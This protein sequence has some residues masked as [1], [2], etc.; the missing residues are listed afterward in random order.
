MEGREDD[1]RERGA[2]PP[3]Y[4]TAPIPPREGGR[5]GGRD[6]WRTRPLPRFERHA[7]T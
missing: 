4:T 6:G 5:E 3:N 1:R 7:R 2:H